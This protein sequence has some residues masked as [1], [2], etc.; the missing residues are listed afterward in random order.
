MQNNDLTWCG[1]CKCSCTETALTWRTLR[2][3]SFNIIKNHSMETCGVERP[4][5]IRRNSIR[6]LMKWRRIDGAWDRDGRSRSMDSPSMLVTYQ[7]TK[8]HRFV[9]QEWIRHEYYSSWP[10]SRVVIGLCV[11]R[12]VFGIIISIFFVQFIVFVHLVVFFSA[13]NPAHKH[14]RCCWSD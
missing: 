7:P 8:N 9:H 12:L 3:T 4:I 14:R 10:P 2:E 1:R 6:G 13:S 5:L 11:V